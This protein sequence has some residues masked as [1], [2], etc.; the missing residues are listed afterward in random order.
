[1]TV[2]KGRSRRWS[3]KKKAFDESRAEYSWKKEKKSR[4]LFLHRKKGESSVNASEPMGVR[5][6]RGKHSELKEKRGERVPSRY[7]RVRAALPAKETFPSTLGGKGKEM[8]SNRCARRKN[9]KTFR[10]PSFREKKNVPQWA[11]K[12]GKRKK[13]RP[14]CQSRRWAPSCPEASGGGKKGKKQQMPSDD[15]GTR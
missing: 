7:F 4:P 3:G 11:S 15:D 6:K 2:G 10:E 1:M 5:G 8:C 12:V 13:R 9:E 14:F